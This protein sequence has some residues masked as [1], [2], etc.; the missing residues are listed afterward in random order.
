MEVRNQ[1]I[2]KFIPLISK[3]VHVTNFYSK[4]SI[5]QFLFEAF[6]RIAIGPITFLKEKQFFGEEFESPQKLAQGVGVVTFNMFISI[7]EEHH[8]F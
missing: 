7:H 5:E 1:P 8:T 6:I 2:V 3:K 4:S